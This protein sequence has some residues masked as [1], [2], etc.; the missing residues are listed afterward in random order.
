[1]YSHMK[2]YSVTGNSQMINLWYPV[3]TSLKTAD[4]MQHAS[5][6]PKIFSV[7]VS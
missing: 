6:D 5:L 4:A 3:L 2:K 7:T 1:M